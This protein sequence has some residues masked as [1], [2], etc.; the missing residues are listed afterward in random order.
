VAVVEGVV[1]AVVADPFALLNQHL[2]HEG[3]LPGRA[4]ET[5]ETD[6]GPNPEGLAKGDMRWSFFWF[7][8]I[9]FLGYER[10]RVCPL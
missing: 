8:H 7:F 5:E 2:V 1:E 10:K 3:N 4:A 9:F 6:F